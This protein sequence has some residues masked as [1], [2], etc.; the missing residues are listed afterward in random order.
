M[1]ECFIYDILF[2]KAHLIFEAKYNTVQYSISTVQYSISTVQY[3]TVQY[4]TVQYSTVQYSTVQ[5][6]EMFP[7]IEES[8]VH[9]VWEETGSR[10]YFT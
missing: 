1:S 5:V 2:L 8:V 6:T 4:S 10:L 9:T 3:S 7:D